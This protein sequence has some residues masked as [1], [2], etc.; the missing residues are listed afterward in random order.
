MAGRSFVWSYQAS[1]LNVVHNRITGDIFVSHAWAPISM[2][3]AHYAETFLF[4]V[5][6]SLFAGAPVMKRGMPPIPKPEVSHTLFPMTQFN[7]ELLIG[8]HV[9]PQ[10]LGY[11]TMG[12]ISHRPMSAALS[13]KLG[14]GA[15]HTIAAGN[16]L[17]RRRP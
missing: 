15:G 8:R 3:S 9:S 14:V 10:K 1:P 17:L 2:R 7:F 6:E 16:R 4:W 11:S 5:L 13:Q 12:K